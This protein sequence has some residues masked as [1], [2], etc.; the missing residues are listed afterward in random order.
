M[1]VLTFEQSKALE[2]KMKSAAETVVVVETPMVEE[3]VAKPGEIITIEALKIKSNFFKKKLENEI[4]FMDL[5][6]N[7]FKRAKKWAK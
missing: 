5:I 2:E 4:N 6:R 7:S 3:D 1:P